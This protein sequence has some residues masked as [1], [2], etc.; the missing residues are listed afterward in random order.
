[1]NLTL[2]FRLVIMSIFQQ[3]VVD[4]K[5]DYFGKQMSYDNQCFFCP[6]V[7]AKDGFNVSLQ[8]HNSNYCST[9][10]GYRELGH[11][12]EEVEF[13]FP[14]EDDILL[15]KYSEM[16]GYTNQYDEN[17]NEIPFDA[18]TFSSVG[19]VGRIP[20][21]VLEELFEKRG[22]IDWEKTISIEQFNNQNFLNIEN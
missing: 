11:T 1:M 5:K 7:Y 9:E 22:G 20:L 12:Y 3:S 15:H 21:T 10:N 18:N 4:A 2:F 17:D 16:Y 14:S 6:K 8:I 19:T 13:G